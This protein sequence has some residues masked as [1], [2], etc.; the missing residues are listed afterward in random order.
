MMLYKMWYKD[1][2]GRMDASMKLCDG[3]GIVNQ[4]KAGTE[5]MLKL[6]LVQHVSAEGA[7]EACSGA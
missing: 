1:S 5:E 3:L 4:D 6:A 2:I 7:V